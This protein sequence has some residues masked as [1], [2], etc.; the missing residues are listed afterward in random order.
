MFLSF[1]DQVYA[2]AMSY[3]CSRTHLL[4]TAFIS[5]PLMGW[6][7][8]HR[9]WKGFVSQPSSLWLRISDLKFRHKLLLKAH[10]ILENGGKH[11]IC[12]ATSRWWF[13]TP[14]LSIRLV[15]HLIKTRWEMEWSALYAG[16]RWFKKAS[17]E[18]FFMLCC[19]NALIESKKNNNPQRKW[20]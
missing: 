4:D 2:L 14:L 19:I 20:D 17:N 18:L 15:L 9:G 8:V 1:L 6:K 11:L 16:S 3:L 12:T 5:L 7:P 10:H 13:I